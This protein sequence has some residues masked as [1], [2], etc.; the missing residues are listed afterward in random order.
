M[1]IRSGFDRRHSVYALV[2][3][4]FILA[5]RNDGVVC[6]CASSC[7]SEVVVSRA[8]RT[9]TLVRGYSGNMTKEFGRRVGAC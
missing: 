9:K 7:K 4:W 5:S 2:F 8:P 1:V 3:A 6:H